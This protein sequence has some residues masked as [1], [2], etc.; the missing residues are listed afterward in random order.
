MQ[1]GGKDGQERSGRRSLQD[2]ERQGRAWVRVYERSLDTQELYQATDNCSTFVIQTNVHRHP[3]GTMFNGLQKCLAIYKRCPKCQNKK[4][5]TRLPSA[6]AFLCAE[7][8]L[9]RD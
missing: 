1:I 8:M 4:T 6:L 9:P 2:S 5:R 3:N 7:L